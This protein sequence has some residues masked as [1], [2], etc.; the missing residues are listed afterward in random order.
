[1]KR[2]F[3]RLGRQVTTIDLVIAAGAI[4]VTAI[5]LTSA[6]RHSRAVS[7]R[8]AGDSPTL[9]TNSAALPSNVPAAKI[10]LK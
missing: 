2:F 7:A 8:E 5:L 1:M 6:V 9:L 4:L 10:N 3:Q